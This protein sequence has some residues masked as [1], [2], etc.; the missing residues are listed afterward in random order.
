L[1]LVEVQSVDGGPDLVG[2][3]FDPVSQPV[4]L[5]QLLALGDQ[6][7]SLRLERA[8]AQFQFLPAA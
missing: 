3:A 8:A 7:L 6:R 1:A 2:E 4:L 5:S